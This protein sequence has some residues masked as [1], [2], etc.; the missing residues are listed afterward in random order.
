MRAACRARLKECE[1]EEKKEKKR[2]HGRRAATKAPSGRPD[3]G[4]ARLRVSWCTAAFATPYPS[5]PA[6]KA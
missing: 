6:N 2:A 3:L 5:I 4:A 1:A